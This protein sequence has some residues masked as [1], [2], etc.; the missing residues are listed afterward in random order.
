MRVVEFRPEIG[1]LAWAVEW[2]QEKSI[3]GVSVAELLGLFASALQQAEYSPDTRGLVVNLE[4]LVALASA[5]AQA[6]PALERQLTVIAVRAQE[7][8]DR[9]MDPV[10]EAIR[11]CLRRYDETEMS[12]R[13]AVVRLRLRGSLVTPSART[14]FRAALHARGRTGALLVDDDVVS[15]VARPE[16]HAAL[17]AQVGETMAMLSDG[18]QPS[19]EQLRVAYEWPVL[20][21][22]EDPVAA[23]ELQRRDLLHCAQRQFPV[24]TQEWCEQLARS[25]D[26]W[27]ARPALALRRTL[28]R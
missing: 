16:D 14:L 21:A 2:C 27:A 15:E 19:L 10:A 3:R 11:H 20:S 23:F 8:M 24:L 17:A 5:F 22:D 28:D 13:T 4:S 25:S 18:R 26:H 6:R 9:R 7:L 1:Y 12:S